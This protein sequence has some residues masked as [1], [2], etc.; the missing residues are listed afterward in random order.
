VSDACHVLTYGCRTI[1]GAA[2]GR[3]GVNVLAAGTWATAAP[4]EKTLAIT[5]IANR[6]NLLIWK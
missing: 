4:T 2:G 3:I 6:L 1:N 5:E